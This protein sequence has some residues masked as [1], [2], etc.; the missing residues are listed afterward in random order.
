[1][2]SAIVRAFS[3]LAS[4]ASAREYVK[5]G[6]V[7]RNARYDNSASAIRTVPHI[8][9]AQRPDEERATVVLHP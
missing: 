9:L 5:A 2:S 4:L 1:L 6:S 3:P 7:L 8:V